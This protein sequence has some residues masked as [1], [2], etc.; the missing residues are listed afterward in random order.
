MRKIPPLTWKAN[1]DARSSGCKPQPPVPV[2]HNEGAH[3][4]AR[5]VV[6]SYRSVSHSRL[7]DRTGIMADIIELGQKPRKEDNLITPRPLEFRRGDWHSGF[8]MMCT[9]NESARYEVH[10][11]QALGSQGHQHIAFVPNH[12]TLDGGYHYTILALFRY[13]D[14]EADMRRVYRLAGMMECV[15]N[16]PSPILR[17]DLLRRFYKTILEEREALNVIWRG[18]V[19]HFLLPMDSE[20]HNP[21]LFRFKIAQAESLKDLYSAI[22]AETDAQF[23]I[24]AES[25]V[26]YMPENL[27]PPGPNLR[28]A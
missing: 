7:K 21:N 22:E 28:R 24:L 6:E 19:A 26:F 16:A 25:Y 20:F 13:R 4:F 5:Q 2:R 23:D 8:A 12:F 27:S 10:R 3:S 17:T 15:T 11:L 1:P 18:N 9:R 14:N